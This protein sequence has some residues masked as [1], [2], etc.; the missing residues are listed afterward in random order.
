MR[1]NIF[2]EFYNGC[3]VP[4]V[5]EDDPEHAYHPHAIEGAQCALRFGGVEDL[6]QVVKSGEA[7]Q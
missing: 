4:H 7:H 1:F 6:S 2:T 5:A 3:K